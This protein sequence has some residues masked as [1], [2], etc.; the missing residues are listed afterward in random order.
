MSRSILFCCIFVLAACG[1]NLSPEDAD[2][3]L[4]DKATPPKADGKY[5]IIIT[6]TSFICY[7]EP[8][9]TE[10][11]QSVA[12]VVPQEGHWTFDLLSDWQLQNTFAEFDR[13]NLS[14]DEDGYFLDG[15]TDYVS[16]G[17]FVIKAKRLV[18][19]SVNPDGTLTF[20]H[21]FNL[22]WDM[23]NGDYYSACTYVADVAGERMHAPWDG[24][25]HTTINNEEWRV[26]KTVLESPLIYPDTLP[27]DHFVTMDTYAQANDES[28]FAITGGFDTLTQV[29]RDSA[30][31]VVD[32]S[33]TTTGFILDS[34]T[35]QIQT[36]VFET[37]LQGT[38][39]PNEMDL[40]FTWKWSVLE[41]GEVYWF[42][43]EH[44]EGVPRY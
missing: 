32:M 31:G 6:P 10:P 23:D 30:T 38:L 18:V 41:T 40:E 28:S 37:N 39:L 20:T 24:T 3:G 27:Y 21:I 34:D 8:Q 4:T 13:S 33:T 29:A 35:N 11:F 9:H 15:R 36:V 25:P 43:R 44:Y 5:N 16:F 42:Q 2:A 7:G 17:I 12:D 22:G 14:W 19:G 1:D 26:K